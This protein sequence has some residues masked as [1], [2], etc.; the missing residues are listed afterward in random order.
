MTITISFDQIKTI[1]LSG[2]GA[3]IALAFPDAQDVQ[4]EGL[5]G[6]PYGTVTIDD[7]AYDWLLKP[8]H[9]VFFEAI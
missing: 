2:L 6:L 4:K 5:T 7:V 3:A 8:S 1:K 9:Y